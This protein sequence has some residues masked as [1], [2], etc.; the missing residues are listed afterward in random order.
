[1]DNISGNKSIK[2]GAGYIVKPYDD[3]PKT[4]SYKN[5]YLKNKATRG[6]LDVRSK[7]DTKKLL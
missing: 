2:K 4:I 5:D 3:L 1:M 6:A 7:D